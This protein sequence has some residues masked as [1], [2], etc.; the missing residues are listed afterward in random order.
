MKTKKPYHVEEPVEKIIKTILVIRG[1]KVM[2]DSDLAA[3]YGVPTKRLNEQ[4]KRNIERFPEDFM[5]QLTSE[6]KSEVV[7]NCDHLSRLKFSYNL[8]YAFTEYGA[9]MAANVLNSP[10]AVRMSVFI[11]RAFVKLREMAQM[12]A[13]LARKIAQLE[14]RVG[15]HDEA[16]VEIIREL[17]RLLEAPLPSHTRRQIGFV[18]SEGKKE[19]E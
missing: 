16:I 9:L 8:P 7:A 1:F 19:N 4:V 14:R 15:E 18:K 3:L 17:R 5:M 6:E 13:Q 2:L 12:N 10:Q 11:V